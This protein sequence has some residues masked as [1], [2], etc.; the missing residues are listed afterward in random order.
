MRDRTSFSARG[1]A[2]RD[3]LDDIDD[4]LAEF[5]AEKFANDAVERKEYPRAC[6]TKNADACVQFAQFASKRKMNPSELANEVAREM[7]ERVKKGNDG[8]K[9]GDGRAIARCEAS[10][11]YVNIS[12]NRARVFE[13]ALKAVSEGGREFGHT[14][15]AKGKKVIIEHTSSNPNAPLHIGN[16]RNVMIGAHLA[17]L[18]KACGHETQETF[19][20]NDLGAQIGLT[21][22]AYSRVVDKLEP[23][24]KI[25]HWI[26]AMY[27]VMN[28]CQELQQVGVKPGDVEVRFCIASRAKAFARARFVDSTAMIN[29]FF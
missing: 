11:V 22:L 26:G 16:L 3:V 12:L 4:E 17:R 29:V 14:D 8:G 19:Y 21:A 9:G 27:A 25:D 15:R 23:Y 28:T 20:V 7:N 5:F 24:M 13:M 18:M 6:R 10:G 2:L 1:D